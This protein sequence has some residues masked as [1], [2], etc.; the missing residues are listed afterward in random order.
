MFREVKLD[1]IERS[2]RGWLKPGIC[3]P[4]RVFLDGV[5]LH[6]VLAVN[7][8]TGSVILDYDPPVIKRERFVAHML[9]GVV[10]MELI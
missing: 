7:R 4:A 8:S 6:R 3:P 10:R 5:E 1:E 2:N 9:H